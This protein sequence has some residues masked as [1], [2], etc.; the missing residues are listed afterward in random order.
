MVPFLSGT[1]N[2]VSMHRLSVKFDWFAPHQLTYF[3]RKARPAVAVCLSVLCTAI[4]LASARMT[5]A[6]E[7]SRNSK[8]ETAHWQLILNNKERPSLIRCRNYTFLLIYI[9]WIK[10][11]NVHFTLSSLETVLDLLA[12]RGELRNFS[13]IFTM[14]RHDCGAIYRDAD[15]YSWCNNHYISG[16][17]SA[18]FR[19]MTAANC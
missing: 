1:R 11:R 13:R 10:C 14:F 3:A 5:W 19:T 18:M 16:P 9:N 12:E 6:G 4:P 2:S 15:E 17:S 7:R 8:S